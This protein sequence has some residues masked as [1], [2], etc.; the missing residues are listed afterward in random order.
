MTT[1]SNNSFALEYETRKIKRDDKEII[2]NKNKE[3]LKKEVEVETPKVNTA[4][5]YYKKG[6]ESYL[7]FSTKGYRDAIKQFDKALELDK[8]D[9]L[10][11]SAKAEAQ[12]LLARE[13]SSR[14]DIL[15][16]TKLESQ[17]F[18]NAY[19][20][21]D[22]QP[23]LGEAHRALSM[24]YFVQERFKEGKREA[25]KA[26]K[27]N[28]EDAE[29]YFL[30]WLNSPDKEKLKLSYYEA[31]DLNAESLEKAL[32][33]NSDIALFYLEVGSTCAS[34]EKYI[35]SQA[36]YEKVLD[37]SPDNEN[38]YTSLAYLNLE[39]SNVEDSLKFFDKA[40]KIEPNYVEAIHGKGLAYLKNKDRI[41]ATEYFNKA[42]NFEYQD[43]CDMI[44]NSDLR[45]FNWRMRQLKRKRLR[46]Q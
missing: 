4:F 45:Y 22:L 21:S 19:I 20:A 11:I 13:L 40:L 25:D 32:N 17:A 37:L 46:I 2:R 41:T 9:A 35:Q 5:E 16:A 10:V 44:S 33:L 6:R 7:L 18:Q 1:F 38:A 30:L 15:E 8:K 27:L 26:I 24:I 12:A 43:A 3:K 39:N 42:C 28:K 14:N 23:E 34:Q 36:N 31:L 29:A